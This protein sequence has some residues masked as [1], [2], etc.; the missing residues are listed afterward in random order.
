MILTLHMAVLN[1]GTVLVTCTTPTCYISFQILIFLLWLL[2]VH[3]VTLIKAP[4]CFLTLASKNSPFLSETYELFKSRKG[5]KIMKNVHMTSLPV[6]HMGDEHSNTNAT[7]SS[8][9]SQQGANYS[10]K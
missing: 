6:S 2:A 5:K 4:F 3:Y 7:D 9:P 10:R 1:M 8:I